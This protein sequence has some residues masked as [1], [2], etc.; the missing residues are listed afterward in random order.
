MMKRKKVHSVTVSTP[1]FDP[2]SASSN[3]AASAGILPQ[4]G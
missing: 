2:G 4:V 1:V 3:L